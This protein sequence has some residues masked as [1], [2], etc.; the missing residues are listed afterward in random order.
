LGTA[1]AQKRRKT[2]KRPLSYL[3]KDLIFLK[4]QLMV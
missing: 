3:G 1:T 2:G 4:R